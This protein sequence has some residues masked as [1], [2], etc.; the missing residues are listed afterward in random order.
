MAI[1]LPMSHG[2]VSMGFPIILQAAGSGNNPRETASD[3]VF[4]HNR[5]LTLNGSKLYMMPNTKNIRIK[6]PNWVPTAKPIRI[7]KIASDQVAISACSTLIIPLVIG[8]YPLLFSISISISSIWLSIWPTAWAADSAK[9]AK[10]MVGILGKNAAK[11]SENE[12]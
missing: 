8:R 2:A 10:I 3:I 5:R 6:I 11:F 4:S 7:E 9:A 12:S 1:T